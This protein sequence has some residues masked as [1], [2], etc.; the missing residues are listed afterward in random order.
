MLCSTQSEPVGKAGSE[1]F[2][3]DV[4]GAGPESC[5]AEVS[6]RTAGAHQ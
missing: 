1:E 4:H 2:E 6:E 3:L 5:Q